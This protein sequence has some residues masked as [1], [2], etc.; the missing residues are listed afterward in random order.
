MGAGSTTSKCD[1]CGH[2]I[3][4]EKQSEVFVVPS[5]KFSK[6]AERIYLACKGAGTDEAA[7]ISVM[8]TFKSD[9]RAK[10]CTAFEKIYSKNMIDVLKKD[11]SGNFQNL[12]VEMFT[13]EKYTKWAE[14]IQATIK[15]AGTDEKR[16]I[17]LVF[18]MTD[19]DQV[20]VQSEFKRLYKEDMVEKIVA[21]IGSADWCQLI[22]GWIKAKSTGNADA[23][24]LADE[25]F[26]AAKGAGTDE[27]T[28]MIVLCKCTPALYVEVCKVFAT[29][30]NKTLGD[31]IEK[32]MSG[33]NEHTF[34]LAHYT[35][36]D[37]RQA[38]AYQLKKALKGAGTDDKSL[39]H[40]TIL[41]SDLVKGGVLQQAYSQFGD[42]AKDIKGDLS[43]NYEKAILAFWGL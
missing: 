10:V 30:Y 32:E 19:E 26:E 35:L 14:F 4:I 3:K 27:E 43:G 12:A 17:P 6:A 24:G 25:L 28:F 31:V 1:K 7:I 5:D 22:K 23:E 15:G 42:I 11:L 20:K 13:G 16:L 36:L 40:L 21:D 2:S 41:F 38:I 18:L 34:L 39:V 29:K 33:K 9:E 8:T 37:R